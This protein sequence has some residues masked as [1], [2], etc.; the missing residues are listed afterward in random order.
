MSSSTRR[1]PR[2]HI[3]AC[4]EG[5]SS[6]HPSVNCTLGWATIAHWTTI[7][8]AR[9]LHRP[10]MIS[11]RAAHHAV[12]MPGSGANSPGGSRSE[13]EPRAYPSGVWRQV[14]SRGQQK[15]LGV[16]IGGTR[17]DIAGPGNFRVCATC[18]DENT[19]RQRTRIVRAHNCCGG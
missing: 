1:R 9:H 7:A 10:P 2:V 14:S 12:S 11:A 16:S 19:V 15:V 13:S 5:S 8:L 6:D 3:A 18:T 4:E 17:G